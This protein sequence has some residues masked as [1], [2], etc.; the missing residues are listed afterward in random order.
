MAVHANLEMHLMDVIT[1]YLY[2]SLDVDIYIKVPPS[3]EIR[4]P[5]VPAPEQYHGIKLHKALYGLKQ[6]ERMWY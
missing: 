3:L 6:C 2:G 4:T 5:N 1:A